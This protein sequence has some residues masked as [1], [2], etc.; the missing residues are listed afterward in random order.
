MGDW[1]KVGAFIRVARARANRYLNPAE[2][3]GA[4]G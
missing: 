1:R 3:C 2:G 4:R